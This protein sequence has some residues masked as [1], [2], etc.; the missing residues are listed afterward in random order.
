MDHTLFIKEYC[1]QK[2]ECYKVNAEIYLETLRSATMNTAIDIPDQIYYITNLKG[3]DFNYEWRRRAWDAP[4]SNSK[5]SIDKVIN[6]INKQVNIRFEDIR[7]YRLEC[8]KKLSN[9]EV[10][11]KSQDNEI[12]KYTDIMYGFNRNGC[13]PYVK[14]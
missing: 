5:Y 14:A 4:A 7:P 11:Y 12:K 10:Y 3:V 1:N 2:I 9:F 13:E 8:L 6:V